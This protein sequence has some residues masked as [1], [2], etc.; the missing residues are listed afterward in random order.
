MESMLQFWEWFRKNN[1]AYAFLN[2]IDRQIK[3]KLLN[4]FLIELHKLS[5]KLYF[6]IGGF[7]DGEQELIITAEGDEDYFNMVEELINTA[8]LISGWKFIAFKQPT[9][10]HFKSEWGGLELATE[11]LWFLP[12][13][14]E[15]STKIGVRIYI[16]NND[17]LKD[18]EELPLLLS[19][20]LDTIIGEKSFASDIEFIETAL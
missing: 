2:S 14:N 17:L 16:K 7:P 9:A 4:D 6:E 13:Y 15:N 11:G 12:L 20:M 8:P 5:N 10:G 19:K 3:N 18:N 1:T